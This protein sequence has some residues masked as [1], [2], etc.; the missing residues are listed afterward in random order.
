M[1][2]AAWPRAYRLQLT[3]TV[4]A[5]AAVPPSEVTE[6]APR[7]RVKELEAELTTFQL[8]KNPLSEVILTIEG[9]RRQDLGVSLPVPTGPLRPA[10]HCS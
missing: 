8:L 2:F 9:A 10:R 7:A 5:L 3:A 4:V 6:M 1:C